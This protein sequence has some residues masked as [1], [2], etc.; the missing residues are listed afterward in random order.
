MAM[1]FHN[2]SMHQSLQCWSE[3][4]KDDGALE[5]WAQRG[6]TKSNSGWIEAS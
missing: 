6:R 1:S 4:M 3:A 5:C 2:R